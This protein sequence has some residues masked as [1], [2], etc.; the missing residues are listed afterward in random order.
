MALMKV[1]S[2]KLT[3]KI[4]EQLSEKLSE[5]DRRALILGVITLGVIAVYFFGIEPLWTRYDELTSR[6]ETHAAKIARIIVNERKAKYYAVQVA[7]RE[8]KVGELLPPKLYSEQINSVSEKVVTA[9]QKSGIKLKGLSYPAPIAWPDDPALKQA[10]I[11]IDAEV[12]WE[13][14]FKFVAAL[15]RLEGV[16]SVEQM[17]LSSGKKG[18]KLTAKMKVSVLVKAPEQSENPWSS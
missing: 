6:H 5:K 2:E 9:A 12:D 1:L 17:E 11:L 14:V 18:G 4:S 3:E 13:N 10:S 15:Y 8:E 7:E 16:L